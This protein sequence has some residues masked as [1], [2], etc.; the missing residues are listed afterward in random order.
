MAGQPIQYFPPQLPAEIQNVANMYQLGNPVAEYQGGFTR[1][2]IGAIVGATIFTAL[3]GFIWIFAA[4]DDTGGGS[5]V[6]AL[7]VL[8]GLAFMAWAIINPIVSSSWHVYVFNQG[9]VFSKGGQPDILRWA[10][11]RAMWQ[12]VTRHYTNGIYTGTT[13]KYTVER[14]DGHR[15]VLNDRIKK[16]EELGNV[17]SQ[18]ITNTMWPHMLAAYNAGNVIS[19]GPLSVS[20]QGLSNGRELLPWTSIK[21]VGVQRGYVSVRKEGKWFNWSTVAVANIPNFFVFLA[22]TRYVLGR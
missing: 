4:N 2:A 16:V 20:Q 22:L 5:I 10:E 13:H 18:Q 15:V 19:F 11:I 8:A 7:F 21:E 12:Q 1:R 14:A 9:F 3:F 6:F 17:L